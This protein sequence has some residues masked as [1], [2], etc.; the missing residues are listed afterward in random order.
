MAD[1]GTAG[2]VECEVQAGA[3][4][5]EGCG[6][7]ASDDFEVCERTAALELD[8]HRMVTDGPGEAAKGGGE[9]ASTH[10]AAARACATDDSA[11]GSGGEAGAEGADE[12]T[13]PS[14]L[15]RKRTA[16]AITDDVA[17]IYDEAEGGGMIDEGAMAVG[18]Q[19]AGA[20]GSTT[21]G[22]R[23]AV[24]GTTRR[25]KRNRRSGD[26]NKDSGCRRLS[27]YNAAYEKPA[28]VEDGRGH[29]DTTPGPVGGV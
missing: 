12:G 9:K 20:S 7:D 2:T 27:A 3:S 15:T 29:P 25:R 24:A 8:A 23:V 17:D 13:P 21:G 14:E 6:M 10:A 16:A 19:G 18:A 22:E 26:S 11:V 5:A 1:T 4:D 28:T